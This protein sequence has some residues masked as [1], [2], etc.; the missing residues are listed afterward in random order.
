VSGFSRTVFDHLKIRGASFGHDIASACGLS[1]TDFRSAIGELAAAGL[2][3]SDGFAG[4]RTLVGVTSH[5]T[6]GRWSVLPAASDDIAR[7][8]AVETLARVLLGRYGVIFRRLL[9]REAANVPWRDLARVYRRLEARGEIRGGRFVSGMS[10]EQFALPDAVERLREVRRSAPDDRL[11]TLSAADPLNLT[12][13]ITAGDRIRASHRIASST[14]TAC[15]L[16]RWRVTCFA[17]ST[18][19]IRRWHS[20]SRRPPPAGACP[21]SAATSV[22]SGLTRP[23]ITFSTCFPHIVRMRI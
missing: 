19:S 18:S 5:A 13:I 3:T 22:A 23:R 4:L 7:D 21:S 8:K 2:V 15:P 16:L 6:V 12:G 1:E 11:I 14:A 17:R 20:R 9:T 10:G